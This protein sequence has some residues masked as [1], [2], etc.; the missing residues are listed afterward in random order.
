MRQ[1]FFR[2]CDHRSGAQYLKKVFPV[3]RGN[4]SFSVKASATDMAT[5]TQKTS[6][7]VSPVVEHIVLFKVKE[8][9]SAET[10]EAMFELLRGLKS[11][12]G[13]LHLSAGPVLNVSSL[14]ET[15]T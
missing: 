10:K 1:T 8:S 13:V 6:S 9:V 2:H 3:S 14:C 4:D 7:T 11:L 5:S 12:D 15:C